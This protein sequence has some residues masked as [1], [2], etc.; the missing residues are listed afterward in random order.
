MVDIK[1]I[2]VFMIFGSSLNASS[3]CD[4]TEPIQIIHVLSAMPEYSGG[5]AA[6]N[7]FIDKNLKYNANMLDGN[8]I[9][10]FVQF[11]VDTLGQTKNHRIIKG[12]DPIFNQE[13]LRVAKLV[14]FDKPAMQGD[15][16][17]QVEYNLPITFK[18]KK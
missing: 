12:A 10:V 5:E 8:K 14:K 2:L 9:I 18:A 15:K 3:Q 17:V 7:K 4:T 16:A 13:A 11:D 6:L 1:V